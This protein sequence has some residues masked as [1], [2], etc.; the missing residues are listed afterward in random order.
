M[1]MATSRALYAMS[2]DALFF[3][4]VCARER[5]RDS[6]A[7]AVAFHRGGPVL[8]DVQL[9]AG[10]GDSGVVFRGRL[11]AVVRVAVRAA[12]PHARKRAAASRLGLSVDDVAGSGGL[13]RVPGGGARERS[14][15]HAADFPR[16]CRELS[17]VPRAQVGVAA[18]RCT[19][20]A[21]LG[22]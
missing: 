3:P 13:D 16:A 5:R 21:T 14:R 2:R 7:V 15:E 19:R 18:Q 8:C 11:R 22:K 9:R 20:S 17:G 10:G 12:A 4:A 6:G 1:E